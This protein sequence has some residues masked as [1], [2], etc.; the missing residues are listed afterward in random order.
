MGSLI[1]VNNVSGTPFVGINNDTNIVT[2]QDERK[3][4]V[5]NPT[6]AS[7]AG[8]GTAR[9]YSFGLRNTPYVNGGSEWDLYL[10]DIQTYTKLTLNATVD[11]SQ[12]PYSS[13]IRGVSSDATGYVCSNPTTVNNMQSEILLSQTSGTFIAGEQILINESNRHVRSISSVNQ[14]GTNDIKSV[15]QNSSEFTGIAADFAADTVLRETDVPGIDPS[16]TFYITGDSTG[17]AGTITSPGNTF[18]EVKVGAVVKYRLP[19]ETLATL[20]RV[21]SI[22]ADLKTLTVSGLNEVTGVTTG[23]VGVTSTSA[24][25]LVVPQI[26]SGGISNDAGLYTPLPDSNVSDVNLASSTLL[27]SQQI[28]NKTPSSGALAIN[29]SDLTGITSSFFSSFDTQKYSIS[30]N[31]GTMADLTA[32]QFDLAVGGTRVNFT[33]LENKAATVN[34]SLIHISEPT[35]PY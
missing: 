15:Y 35:R 30:Y 17:N 31:D 1:R 14:Y 29:V 23:F 7:G 2:L 21:A 25:T 28:A 26:V 4:H 32:D 5:A 33:G 11:S 27:V 20:N 16:S 10:Y 34:L 19:G 6:S 9:V 13:Y 22:S 12:C 18:G 8:I 3:N 24:I